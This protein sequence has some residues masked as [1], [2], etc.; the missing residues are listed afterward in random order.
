MAEDPRELARRLAEE[1]KA[2]LESQGEDPRDLAR[3]LAEEAKQKLQTTPAPSLDD[4]PTGPKLTAKQALEREREARKQR[5]V[6]EAQ[7]QTAAT[8]LP[9]RTPTID[10]VPRTRV[11]ATQSSETTSPGGAGAVARILSTAIPGATVVFSAPVQ[12]AVARAVWQSHRAR[13][14]AEH[15]AQLAT[16]ASVILDALRD[17]PAGQLVAVRATVAGKDWAFWVDVSTERLLA[18]AF[19][20]EVYLAGV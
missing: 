14:Q 1:A 10:E 4:A 2:K 17:V 6:A 20:A 3:R 9:P 5:K 16:T 12:A 7:A 19:P 18:T 15:D 8:S 13:A 11:E